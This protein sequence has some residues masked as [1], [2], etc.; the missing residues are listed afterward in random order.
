MAKRTRTT[1]PATQDALAV[2]GTQIAV[3]RR[4]LGW[5][6]SEL[7]QRVGVSAPLISRIENGHPT[8]QVGTV[9]DAAVL[10]GVPLF[11]PDTA[12]LSRLAANARTQLALI[13]SRVRRERVELTDD[14]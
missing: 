6:A 9:F 5:T 13:P 2:L 4:E 14:F 11:A 7:A 12:T 1:L 10:C 8:T 3:A